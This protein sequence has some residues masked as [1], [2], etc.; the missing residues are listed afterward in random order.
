MSKGKIFATVI[1]TVLSGF[2][3][4][5]TAKVWHGSNSI[6]ISGRNPVSQFTSLVFNSKKLIG[7]SQGQVN[8]LLLGVGGEGHDGPYL[9]DTILVASIRPETNEVA[10]TS[11]PRDTHVTIPGHPGKYKINSAYAFGVMNYGEKIALTQAR[12]T[13][14]NYLGIEIPYSVVVDFEGFRKAID[15]VGGVDVEIDKTFTDYHYPNTKGGYIPPVTFKA[16]TEHMNGGRA[17]I[18]ARSRHSTSD[19]DRSRRQQKIIEAFKD[20]IKE[21]NLLSDF[22]TLSSLFDN[23]TGHISTNLDAGEI[24]RLTEVISDVPNNKIHTAVLDPTT[25]LVCSYT[26]KELGYHI[27]LCPGKTKRD[28]KQFVEN[29]FS[30]GRMR[31]ENPIVEVQNATEIPGHAYTA[32]AQLGQVGFKASITNAGSLSNPERTV[33]YDLTNGQKPDSLAVLLTTFSARLGS[34][35]PVSKTSLDPDFIVVLGRNYKGPVLDVINLDP[36]EP[37]EGDEEDESNDETDANEDSLDDSGNLIDAND[38]SN[39]QPEIK[40]GQDT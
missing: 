9:S 19:F 40:T 33:V 31:S 25:G 35:P 30:I 27:E 22:R 14:S 5:A 13:V 3:G 37:E 32:S 36:P 34:T 15:I 18:Y 8:I 1:L 17:L 6:F 4:Y 24:K 38:S 21:L 23:F 20:K 11:V 16:G 29:I 26:S 2:V 12:E 28:I 39:S 10:L 7:E